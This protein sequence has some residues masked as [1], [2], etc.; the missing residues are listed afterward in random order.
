MEIE[1]RR[2]RRFDHIADRDRGRRSRQGVAAPH[3]TCAAHDTGAAQP[4]QNLLH[5]I[6]GKALELGDFPDGNRPLRRPLGEVEGANDAVLGERGNAHACNLSARVDPCNPFAFQ[7]PAETP[8]FPPGTPISV[9][10]RR[11]K[12][13]SI[14]SSGRIL[15]RF[16][17]SRM[18]TP[19]LTDR[20]L[21]SAARA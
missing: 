21:I 19:S 10:L 5:V 18:S 15:S 13:S 6:A 1:R 20:L 3:T 17:R 7:P 9:I 2:L 14:S 4:E 12:T 11:S 8:C 16:T